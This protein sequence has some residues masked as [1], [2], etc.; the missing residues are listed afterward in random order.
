MYVFM[1]L[2]YFLL[3]S[4]V[5]KGPSRAVYVFGFRSVPPN[6]STLSKFNSNYNDMY[7]AVYA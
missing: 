4:L 1:Y 2:I 7:I 3:V 5:H 6:L